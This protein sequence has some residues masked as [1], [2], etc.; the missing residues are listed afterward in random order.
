MSSK[1]YKGIVLLL[2][3]VCNLSVVSPVLSATNFDVT[4]ISESGQTQTNVPITIGQPF[5]KGEI[6]I[7]AD[8]NAKTNLSAKLSNG[9]YIPLQVNSKATHSDGTLRHAVLSM[10]V[11]VLNPGEVKT[12]TISTDNKAVDNSTPLSKT[13]LL[14]TNFDAVVQVNIGGTVYSASA[15]DLLQSLPEKKWLSGPVVTEWMVSAPLQTASKVSH[16]HLTARFHIRAYSGMKSVRADVTVENNWTFVSNPQNVTYDATVHIGGAQAYTISNL[17]H[18]HHA[19][20][21]KTFWWGTEPAVYAKHDTNYLLSTRAVPN[22]DTSIVITEAALAKEASDLSDSNTNPMQI[23]YVNKYM[24]ATGGRPD[25]GPVPRWTARYL[26][27]MDKRVWNTTF[28]IGELAGSWPIHYRDKATDQP[29]SIQDHTNASTNNNI[30]ICSANCDTGYTA[31]SAHQP[32]FVYVPYLLTGDYYFLEELAF[33]ANFNMLRHDPGQRGGGKGLVHI[34]QVRGE[35]WALR[36]M[37][38]AG[39]ILPN[40]HPLKQYFIDRVNDNLDYYNTTYAQNTGQAQYVFGRLDKGSGSDGGATSKPWM[41]D[42]FTWS[43]GHIAD[44]GFTKAVELRD[45]KVKFSIGRMTDPG[46]CWLNAGQYTTEAPGTPTTFAEL[47][48]NNVAYSLANY[49]TIGYIKKWTSLE[50]CTGNNMQ[51]Y[52]SEPQ[53]YV[54]ILQAALAVAADSGKA[55]AQLAWNRYETRSTKVDYGAKGP[56]FAIVPFNPNA[57]NLSF[58]SSKAQIATT[59][60]VTLN[61]NASSSDTCTASGDWTGTKSV[62]GSETVGPFSKD[63]TFILSCT[64]TDGDVSGSVLVSVGENGGGGTTSIISNLNKSSYKWDELAVDTKV[65]VDRSYLYTTVPAGYVGYSVL[66]TGN[67]DKT[68]TGNNFLSFDVSKDITV[69]VAYVDSEPLP[70]WMS[71][72]TDT[73]NVLGT[74]DRSLRVYSK[75]FTAGKVSL[76][77]N[78]TAPSMY[79]VLLET[80]YESGGE[81]G[82]PEGSGGDGSKSPTTPTGTNTTSGGGGSLGLIELLVGLMLVFANTTSSRNRKQG[83]F[84]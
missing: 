57:A 39:Y 13:Q 49:Q 76:G 44:L 26:I 35:A 18:N 80:I 23:A 61:W 77:G 82:T 69:L 43:I 3:L 14:A 15:K 66:Q 83:L 34:S 9:E 75:S 63:A 71:G 73:G 64:G 36:T 65:Y 16:P 2:G 33:W 27:S 74:S 45:Y 53:G 40:D 25:I 1:L 72:W 12:I 60:K 47:H 19:R 46:Y 79:T 31:D 50:E 22:Y 62:S 59:E 28:T 7:G 68:S 48:A 78:E 51:G 56:E 5:K 11:P 84:K 21:R 38:H 42:F 52:A 20:W 81:G 4:V 24:K 32:S 41:D 70:Q 55:N 8:L 10:N 58:S 6:A 54:A 67:N 29:V 37:A 17:T 30:A